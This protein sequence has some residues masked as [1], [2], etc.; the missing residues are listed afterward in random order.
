[1]YTPVRFVKGKIDGK[2]V[3]LIACRQEPLTSITHVLE[4]SKCLHL[5]VIVAANIGVGSK[6]SF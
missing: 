6:E 2:L 1:M 3:V 4:Q 5:D